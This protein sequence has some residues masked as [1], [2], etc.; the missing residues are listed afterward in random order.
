M[1]FSTLSDPQMLKEM[2]NKISCISNIHSHSSHILM[3]SAK[4]RPQSIGRGTELAANVTTEARGGGVLGLDM[5]INWWLPVWW[6]IANQTSPIWPILQH[7]RLNFICIIIIWVN[8]IHWNCMNCMYI[9]IGYSKPRSVCVCMCY[10]ETE[11]HFWTDSVFH[12]TDKHIRRGSV[13][14]Q[15]V[16]N[17]CA[18]WHSCNR[19]LNISNDIQSLYSLSSF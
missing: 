7:L 10:C 8:R 11:G 1:T 16:Q 5:V 18:S 15:H 17:M 9:C 12:K 3:L 19:I 13:L 2:M 14:P 4:M 6:V